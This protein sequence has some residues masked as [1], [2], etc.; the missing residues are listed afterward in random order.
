M[1]LRSHCQ[2]SKD[3]STVSIRTDTG[4]GGSRR[5][6]VAPAAEQE[7]SDLLTAVTLPRTEKELLLTGSYLAL[8]GG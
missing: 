4:K 5:Q 3:M 8:P 2:D 7:G 6:H 1:I